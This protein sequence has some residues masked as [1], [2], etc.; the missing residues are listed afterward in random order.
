MVR[1]NLSDLLAE[2][3]QRFEDGL[4]PFVEIE[5]TKFLGCGHLAT[6]FAR[7][8]CQSCGQERL[9]ALTCTSHKV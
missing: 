9:V 4:P 7:L 3:Q 2:A 5:L 8:K 1:D 6:G